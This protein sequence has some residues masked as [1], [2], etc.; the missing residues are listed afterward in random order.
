ME[1]S[2]YGFY[3]FFNEVVFGWKCMSC[4]E[5]ELYSK[6]GKIWKVFSSCFT[7]DLKC[8]ENIEKISKL[9]SKYIAVPTRKLY[10][11]DEYYGYQMDDAGLSLD[12]YILK[13]NPSFDIII[14]ILLSVKEAILY[15]VDL[16]VIHGDIS[17]SNIFVD[18]SDEFHIRLGDVTS[19]IFPGDQKYHIK[20]LHEY[21]Y[22]Y[23][24][25]IKVI[26]KLAYDLLTYLLINYYGDSLNTVVSNSN[27]NFP[28]VLKL[29]DSEFAR[30]GAFKS[31]ISAS[32]IDDITCNNKD[33]TLKYP[34]T[35]LIDCL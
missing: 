9:D 8:E 11:D 6:D 33:K 28:D 35:Y 25:D 18:E 3:T 17:L 31:T 2:R 14:N 24:G 1:K 4:R 34:N 16:D 5:G 21:W 23:Y 30:R 26:D 22:K 15:L 10:L 27:Y 29:L 7:P 13:N 20:F 32:L 12:K 19:M